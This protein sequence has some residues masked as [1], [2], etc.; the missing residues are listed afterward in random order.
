MATLPA[1]TSAFQLHSRRFN[2]QRNFLLLSLQCFIAAAGSN[3]TTVSVSTPSA[4]SN[5]NSSSHQPKCIICFQLKSENITSLT[6]SS[7][8]DDCLRQFNYT[9]H[10]TVRLVTTDRAAFLASHCLALAA[11]QYYHYRAYF[12]VVNQT[13]H[14]CWVNGTLPSVRSSHPGAI[15][16]ASV[17]LLLVLGLK[18][19]APRK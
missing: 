18:Y 17:I 12:R 8:H 9:M 7:E 1:L 15:R 13:V 2:L 11:S 4:I 6:A 5:A 14:Y 19:R 16:W 10:E 3:T